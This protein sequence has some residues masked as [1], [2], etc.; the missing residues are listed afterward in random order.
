MDGQCLPLT[1]L[2]S[3]QAH[4]DHQEAPDACGWGGAGARKGPTVN[5]LLRAVGGLGGRA[6]PASPGSRGTES[7]CKGWG[8][9][10]KRAR[11]QERWRLEAEPRACCGLLALPCLAL[12]GE[13]GSSREKESSLKGW[14]PAS[15][16]DLLR[17]VQSLE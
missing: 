2:P 4:F 17:E 12:L 5:G 10:C 6:H 14:A 15:T 11:V 1:I 8:R 9:C 3:V 13:K 7:V 16:S